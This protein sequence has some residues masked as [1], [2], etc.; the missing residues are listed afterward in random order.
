LCNVATT[1]DVTYITHFTM[2]HR[3]D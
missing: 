2:Q 1:L 3:Q